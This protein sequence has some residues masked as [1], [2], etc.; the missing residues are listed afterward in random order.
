MASGN[1]PGGPGVPV[2]RPL[3]FGHPL[4]ALLEP[5]GRE[6]ALVSLARLDLLEEYLEGA[7]DQGLGHRF[8]TGRE[9]EKF[10]AL[11]LKKRRYEWLGGRLAAKHAALNMVKRRSDDWQAL[12]IFN[13]AAGRPWVEMAG[14]PPPRLHISISHSHEL[15]AAV[16]AFHPCGIDVQR[17]VPTVLRVKDRFAG[18]AEL[19]VLQA[20]D[21][22]AGISETA[23]LTL[24]WS[25]KEVVR[26][27][28]ALEKLLWFTELK[29]V[30]ASRVQAGEFWYILEVRSMR[31][32]FAGEAG[33][34]FE[35]WAQVMEDYVLACATLEGGV[36]E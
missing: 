3:V 13:D 28:V 9:L 30:K 21:G 29:V 2:T 31:S 35:I 19:E 11:R 16:A 23:R 15:A 26:K 6:R 27:M 17:I 24:L 32:R 18:A 8:L 25:V 33:N 14:K 5:Q 4:P 22:L 36:R 10:A 12:E 20:E 34:H 1:L 7:A